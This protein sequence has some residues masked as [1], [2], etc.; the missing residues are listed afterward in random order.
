MRNFLERDV[1]RHKREQKEAYRKR[2]ERANHPSR[3]TSRGGQ[4][5]LPPKRAPSALDPPTQK[6]WREKKG[7]PAPPPSE[8]GGKSKQ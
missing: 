7:T 8:S 5:T 1:R 2:K 4:P 3:P 6:V